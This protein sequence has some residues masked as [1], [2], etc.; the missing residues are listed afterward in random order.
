MSTGSTTAEA[1]KPRFSRQVA[2]TLGARLFIA[3]GSLLTGVIV[4]RLL[5]A[6]S[7]GILASLNV[8][9]LVALTFGGIGLPSAITFLVA[10]DRKRLKPVLVNAFGFAVAVGGLLTFTIIVLAMLKPEL[11]GGIQAKL[12]MI[13]AFAIPFQFLQLCCLGLFLGLGNIGRYN[14]FD[15][16]SQALL[17]VNPLVILWLLGMGLPT[18]VSANVLAAAFLSMLALFFL[19]RTANRNTSAGNR[20]FDLRLMGEMLRYGSKFYIAMSASIIIIRA[21][22]LIVNYFRGS[23]EAGV[24]A[25][26]TQVGTLLMLLPG[27]I[28]TV[29]FP[30]VSEAPDTG[31]EM[32][33]RVTRHASLVM[34]LVCLAAIPFAFLLPLLYGPAFAGVPLLVLI[35]LP[36]VYLLGMETVQVQYFSS[37]G[38]PRAIPAF[39]VAALAVTLSLDLIFVPQYGAYAAAAVSSISYAL[40]FV[41]VAVYFRKWTGMT[42]ADSFLLSGKELRELLSAGRSLAAAREGKA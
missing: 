22:L 25:V 23:A 30:R 14:L 38:L 1:E 42:F 36:G 39:W 33:C 18:L 4:A 29:L 9:T 32:T 19:L 8:I 15:V 17:V 10:R 5:G 27:V 34:L 26:A 6:E 40:M 3:A 20:T 2:W 31:A 24:Y 21:D 41:L 12:V 13:V 35:L 28:S 16:L 37:I 7:V 11:F